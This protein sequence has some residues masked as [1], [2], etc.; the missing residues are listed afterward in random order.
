[1]K[2]K[3]ITVSALRRELARREKGAGKLQKQ[4][5]K[6]ASQ[7][8]ALEADLADLGMDGAPAR[9][10]R[11]PG[12]P[13]GSAKR[14]PGRLKGSKNRGPGRPK[15]SKNKAGGKRAKN[16]MS[17]V[18]AILKGV[19]AGS[20]V[21]PAEA[22]AAARKLG[23]KSSSPNFGMM[24]ANALSKDSHFKRIERGQYQVIGGKGSMKASTRPGRKAKR[25]SG[26]RAAGV[27]KAAPSKA[28]ATTALA[29]VVAR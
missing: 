7:L 22:G 23:Y 21:S 12:R 27:K 19:R 2:L 10:T 11:K 20:T 26:G 3:N 25:K 29:E 16:A 17:L 14:G 8:A 5:A 6:L 1:M 13:A 24:V 4:H 18:Q 15:G 9:H 28:A